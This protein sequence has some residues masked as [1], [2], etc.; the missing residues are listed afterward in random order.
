MRF[1]PPP[2]NH[3]DR[4]IPRRILLLLLF[5]LLATPYGESTWI[6]CSE[7]PNRLETFSRLSNVPSVLTRMKAALRNATDGNVLVYMLVYAGK[8]K[9]KAFRVSGWPACGSR[10]LAYVT[11][12]SHGQWNHEDE[13]WL[14]NCLIVA[15]GRGAGQ[16]PGHLHA[17]GG[18]SHPN[19]A[20]PAVPRHPRTEPL[21]QLRV[22]QHVLR[23]SLAHPC[24][25]WH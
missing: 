3:C 19:G 6:P 23:K 8:T 5:L 4:R 11:A 13:R 22:S 10:R 7:N 17:G 2:A 1:K 15:A 9:N 24:Q 18:A 14:I 21:R 12:G 20:G 25:Y 16:G